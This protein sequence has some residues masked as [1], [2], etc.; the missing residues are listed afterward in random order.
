LR[1][2][3]VVAYDSLNDTKSEPFAISD[4]TFD[5][6]NWWITKNIED[7]FKV[8]NLSDSL[9]SISLKVAGEIIEGDPYRQIAPTDIITIHLKS[10]DGN[11]IATLSSQDLNEPENESIRAFMIS[12]DGGSEQIFNLDSLEPINEDGNQYEFIYQVSN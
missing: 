1:D 2:I 10:S 3:R 8:S 7:I 11:Y 9:S 6:S 4:A 12:I 5:I